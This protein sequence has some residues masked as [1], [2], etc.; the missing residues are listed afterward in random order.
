MRQVG[1]P[2]DSANLCPLCNND[3][4]LNLASHTP[5][6]PM[7]QTSLGPKTA[8]GQLSKG[9]TSLSV[10]RRESSS[11][12]KKHIKVKEVKELNDQSHITMT[13]SIVSEGT[14]ALP[15]ININIPQV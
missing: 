4:N 7:T 15:S 14:A 13:D 1:G 2:S 5:G 11:R 10:M 8:K 9:K 3:A 12:V 6:F